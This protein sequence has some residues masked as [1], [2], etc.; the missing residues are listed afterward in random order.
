MESKFISNPPEELKY[1]VDEINLLGMR[2]TKSDFFFTEMLPL[3]I[4]RRIQYGEIV[5]VAGSNTNN[6]YCFDN[7]ISLYDYRDEMLEVIKH[8]EL[9]GIQKNK[10]DQFHKMDRRVR[11]MLGKDYAFYISNLSPTPIG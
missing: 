4:Q 11:N 9:N 8:F 5:W 1:L 7:I 2:Y 3:F 10:S 6:S